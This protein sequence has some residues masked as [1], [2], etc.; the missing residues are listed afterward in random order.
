M[1][2]SRFSNWVTEKEGK[3]VKGKKGWKKNPQ[4]LVEHNQIF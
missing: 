2:Q 4:R 1:G 3:L